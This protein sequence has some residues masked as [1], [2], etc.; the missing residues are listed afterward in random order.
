MPPCWLVSIHAPAR[1]ATRSCRTGPWSCFNPRP[2]AGSDSAGAFSRACLT[3]FQSTPPRG[4]RL[5]DDIGLQRVTLVSIHAP[6]REATRRYRHCR[7]LPVSIHAPAREATHHAF[8]G[9]TPASCFNPRPRAGS[10]EA[11]PQGGGDMFQSTPPRGKRPRGSPSMPQ[12]GVVSIHAPAREATARDRA[13]QAPSCFNPR[14]R[15]GSDQQVRQPTG[16]ARF[17]S[18]PPRGKRR[19]AGATAPTGEKWVSIHAPAREATARLL[20][21]WSFQSTPPRGKRLSLPDLEFQSTPP[22][23]KRLCHRNS[24]RDS[25]KPM[26]LREHDSATS[27][28]DDLPSRGSGSVASQRTERGVAACANRPAQT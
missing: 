14:P 19:A 2:R 21:T 7:E 9:A 10:D 23:G 24:L 22:R 13:C 4:K 27:V 11:V 17:Q 6:A 12:D 3:P 25:R 26:S 18:T 5:E 1:E 8:G 20:R 16:H 28:T 15:A